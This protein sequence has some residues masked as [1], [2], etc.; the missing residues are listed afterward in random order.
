MC[1]VCV[2]IR[3]LYL[4]VLHLTVQVLA[5]PV[6]LIW[7]V[8]IQWRQKV[9]LYSSLCLLIFVVIATIIRGS[10]MQRSGTIDIVWQ[11]YWLLA[12][13]QIGLFMTAAT[14]YRSF[15]VARSHEKQSSSTGNK[16][17]SSW[18]STF[19]SRH[20][21]LWHSRHHSDPTEDA[22]ASK[23]PRKKGQF[24]RLVPIPRAHMT[25]ARTFIDAMGRTQ[26]TLVAEEDEED[27]KPLEPR[28]IRVTRTYS[29][30]SE[31][32]TQP[33]IHDFEAAYA[34]RRP[35]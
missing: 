34:L 1:S 23:E 32:A 26:D 11:T 7:K 28:H 13:A 30:H 24:N 5:I 31:R 6:R 2:P 12:C 19:L 14:A 21:R 10:G 25:G 8:Q 15:F 18:L 22:E 3:F 29:Q 20:G 35:S 4:T 27:K 16:K 33:S 17:S 9:G